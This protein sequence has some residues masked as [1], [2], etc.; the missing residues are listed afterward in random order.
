MS[1]H[2]RAASGTLRHLKLQ[3]KSLLKATRAA[4]PSA[5]QLIAVLGP[6]HAG[7]AAAIR[8]ADAQLVIVRE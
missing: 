5:L 3:V 2:S 6:R 4:E 8:V 1:K 7:D